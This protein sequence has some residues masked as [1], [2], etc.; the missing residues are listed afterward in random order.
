MSGGELPSRVHADLRQHLPDW[1]REVG[2]LAGQMEVEPLLADVRRLQTALHSPSFR[3]ALAGAVNAGKATLVNRLV[4]RDTLPTGATVNIG[5]VV[6][7]ASQE[8]NT[9]T[10]SWPDDRHE[11][12]RLDRTSWLDLVD[13]ET[14]SPTA[15][16][17]GIVNGWLR[18]HDIEIVATPGTNESLERFALVRSAVAFSDAA[19]LTVSADTPFSLTDRALLEEDLLARHVPNV[20]VV[21][22]KLDHVAIVEEVLEAVRV[23]VREVSSEI[24]VLAGP[25][26]RTSGQTEIDAIRSTIAELVRQSRPAHWRDRQIAAR[27][28]DHLD[29]LVGVAEA[30]DRAVRLASSERAILRERKAAQVEACVRDWERSRVE[31]ARRRQNLTALLHQRIGEPRG[32]LLENLQ[33]EVSKSDEPHKWW[34]NDLPYR[35][36]QALIGLS[37][38]LEVTL[39]SRLTADLEWLEEEMARI[40]DLKALLP[41]PTAQPITI[42][43][44]I[45]LSPELRPLTSHRM[46]LDLGQAVAGIIGILL[47]AVTSPPHAGAFAI[48]GSAAGK[49]VG[50]FLLDRSLAEQRRVAVLHLPDYVDT[51]LDAFSDAVVSRVKE[52][53]TAEFD[54]LTHQ[55]MMWRDARLRALEDPGPEVEFSG[56]AV[57]QAAERLAKTIRDALTADES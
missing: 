48:G 25:G 12:R 40:F 7:I 28:A 5:Q 15:I 30:D 52:L 31:L 50:S 16:G 45:D 26:L 38:R 2:N 17:V 10:V 19:L 35:F 37:E 4:D 14:T 3:V 55:S 9:L 51:N 32:Q 24:P 29:G 21:V 47:G 36:R 44:L 34:T 49:T 41:R 8:T 11:N 22:T 56:A 27:L 54:S 1:L 53:Y 57:S 43:T 18:D 23:R 20:L 6:T 39:V 42:G 46:F 13:P 33:F